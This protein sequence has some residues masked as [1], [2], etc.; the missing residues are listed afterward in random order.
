M[1]SGNKLPITRMNK[2]FSS[3]DWDL[4]Q[5]MSREA[6]EGDGNFT[7]ILYRVDRQSS[8]KDDIYGESSE[9][10][11]KFFPPIELKVI[12][13]IELPNNDTYNPNGTGRFIDDGNVTFTIYNQQLN[14][15]KTNISFGDYIGYPISESE[16]R[17]YSVANDGIKA[18][19]NEHTIMGYKSAYRTI[20]C[21][22]VDPNEFTGI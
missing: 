5:S 6:I 9:D 20:V 13:S 11:I 17:Y 1:K 4:E 10:G 7:V 16:I 3:T 12:P 19:D 18:F 15:L 14:E 21:T 2:W 8:E 22:P